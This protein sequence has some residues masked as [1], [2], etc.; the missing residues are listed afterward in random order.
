VHILRKNKEMSK[1][2]NTVFE[3]QLSKGTT[4][5]N[6]KS[7]E[8][9]TGGASTTTDTLKENGVSGNKILDSQLEK[10]KLSGAEK[11]L[12]RGGYNAAKDRFKS[13]L[14]GGSK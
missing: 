5:L 1:E 8:D 3:N 10:T 12:V 4:E 9:L 13:W 14:G 11:D 6:T 2:Q 7:L